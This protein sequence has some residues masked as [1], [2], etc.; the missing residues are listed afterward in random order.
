MTHVYATSSHLILRQIAEPSTEI[1]TGMNPDQEL[2]LLEV[3]KVIILK[4]TELFSETPEEILVEIYLPPLPERTGTSFVE[5][6]RRHGDYAQAGVAAVV[7]LGA[8]GGVADARLVYLS[9][10]EV[11]MRARQAEELLRSEGATEEAIQAAAE[12]AASEEIEPTDDIHATEAFKRHLAG[13]VTRRAL[14]K[15]CERARAG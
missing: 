11:P 6:A 7:T 10:G 5:I 14:V 2:H 8:T 4:S 3:E 13:A 12:L 1:A 9:A 15:A